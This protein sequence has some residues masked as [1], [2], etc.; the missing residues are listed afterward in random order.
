MDDLEFIRYCETHCETP[1]A[2]FVGQNIARILRLAGEDE[3]AKEW[4]DLGSIVSI[5][6]EAMLPMCAKARAVQAAK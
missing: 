6:P 1:R 2:G 5:R 3:K 4:D